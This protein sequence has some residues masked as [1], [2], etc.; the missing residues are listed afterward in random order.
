MKRSKSSWSTDKFQ[1]YLNEGRGKG[2]G[3]AYLPWLN[4]QSIPSVGRASRLLGV[5]TGR[6]HHFFSDTQRRYFLM[7]DWLDESVMDIRE[8]YPLL[9]LTEILDDE[10]LN[11]S[12]YQ[13]ESGKYVLTTTFLITKKMPNGDIK[14]FAR[15]VKYASNLEQ[16]GVLE[17]LE[18]ERRYWEKKGKDFKIVTNKDINMIQ[19]RNIEWLKPTA[20]MSYTHENLTDI[21]ML[22]KMRYSQDLPLHPIL[23]T[24]DDDYGFE[25]GAA[26]QTFK[27]MVVRRKAIIDFSH[28]INIR[29]KM[30]IIFREESE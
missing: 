13:E 7:L 25:P 19:V 26:L 18:I 29:N 9:D 1:R 11:L 15:S 6:V 17:A 24:I 20:S 5:T 10:D 22:I 28:P 30:D 14:E 2:E 8:H 16:K 12:K 21:E 3:Q 23:K 27:H 4:A